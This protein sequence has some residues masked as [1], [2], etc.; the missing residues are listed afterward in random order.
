MS[1]IV[2]KQI[3]LVQRAQTTTSAGTQRSNYRY[4]VYHYGRNISYYNYYS[5][6][7]AAYFEALNPRYWRC[8]TVVMLDV[9]ED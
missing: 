4:V 5:S 6:K 7:L 1:D 2:S 8:H 3:R 9:D